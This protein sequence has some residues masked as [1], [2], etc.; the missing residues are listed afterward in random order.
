M[1]DAW[2]PAF[3][4]RRSHHRAIAQALGTLTALGRRTLSRSI[5]ALGRQQQDWSADYRLHARSPWLAHDLFQPILQRALPWCKGRYIAVA[6][7]DTRLHKTGRRIKTAFYQRDPLSPKFR[8]NLMFGLRFLQMS[9]LVPL[10]RQQKASPRGLPVRFDEVP[11]IK[12]PARNAPKDA[13]S[14][15]RQAVK[16]SNLS[17]RAVELI[18]GLRLSLDAAGA[19]IKRLLIVGDGSFCNRTLFR[20][21]LDRT[22]IIARARRDFKLCR[23]APAGSRR[24]YDAVRFTPDEVRLDTQLAWNKAR[25]F[26]AGQWRKIKYKQLAPVFWRT[27]GGKRPLRLFVVEGVPYRSG[28]R[29]RRRDPAFLLTTD[30]S[31]TARELLQAYF[32]RWQIGVSRQ[33]HIAQSVRDRPRSKD[34][35]LVAGEASWRESKAAEPSDKHARKECAQRTR[36]QRAVNADVASLHESPVAETV[37]NARK[38]QEV[39]EMSPKRQPPPAGYQRRH[40]VKDDVETGEALG[41]RRRNLVEEIPAITASGKCRHRHQGGGSGRSTVEGRA[42][43]HARREGPGPVSIPSVKARQG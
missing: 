10:Y 13:W 25:I 11:A 33:G 34:S 6:V 31:G 12:R 38:Q 17:Q 18:G 16:K 15:Y 9:L 8:F 4:Q 23:R 32:D 29:T 26:Y 37:D 22:E 7:D 35:G 30:L 39:A 42:A 28:R 36:L 41:A 2:R 43:K 3:P 5:W 1:L 24:F 40:G 20:P 21:V 27:G 14:A 19:A